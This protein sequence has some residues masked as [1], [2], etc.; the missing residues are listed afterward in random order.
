MPRQ[1]NIDN[2]L[3]CGSCVSACPVDAIQES[4]GVIQIDANECVD[5]GTCQRICPAQ[6]IDG[7][8]NQYL[9]LRTH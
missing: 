6:V 5:C 8:H 7:G 3:K 4:N 1:I 9:E 2:C